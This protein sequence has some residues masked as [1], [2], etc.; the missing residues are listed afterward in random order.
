MEIYFSAEPIFTIGQFVV[1]NT[2]LTSVLSTFLLFIL[3][4]IATR[5]LSNRPSLFQNLVELTIEDL[6]KV[7]EGISGKNTR[8]IFPWF[9]TFFLFILVSN[10]M[11]LLPG[12]GTVGFF[13]HEHGKDVFIPLLRPA[14]TDLNMTLGLALVSLVATHT[15]SIS[16]LGI[17]E[18]IS[19]FVSFNPLNLFVGLLEI[20]SEFTKVASLSLRLIGN[21]FAGEAVLVTTASFLAFL[22]PLPFIILEVVVGLVQALIFAMLT[23]VFMTILMTSH[24]HAKE[25]VKA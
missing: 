2:L 20:I 13:Q 1:T 21:V 8:L 12:F 17:K 16:T 15:L 6:Y 24:E 14:N 19:R 9:A 23:M 3:A 18:Y 22:I 11:G 5:K 25:E 10:W 7:N 4:I